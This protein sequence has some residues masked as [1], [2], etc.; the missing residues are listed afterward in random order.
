MRSAFI[1]NERMG[2]FKLGRDH[3]YDPARITRVYDLC[4][5]RGLFNRDGLRVVSPRPLDIK[6]FYEVH[7]PVY[8]ETL[9]TA[10]ESGFEPWMLK[11]GLGTEDCPVFPGLLEFLM[12]CAGAT[13]EAGTWVMDAGYDFAFNPLGGFHHAGRTQAEGFCYVND[14]CL[15]ARRWAD[16]GFRVMIVDVDAHHGNGDQDFFY[17]DPRVFTL[18]FHES[19]KTLYPFGGEVTEIGRGPGLG[20]NVNVPMPAGSDDEIFDF[21]FNEVFPPLIEAFS[22]DVAIGI[23]GVDTF[24]TDPLTNLKMTNN[25]YIRAAKKI[26]RLSPRWIALGAGG[27]NMDNVIRSWTLLW[28][29]ANGLDKGDDAMET[30]GGTFMRDMDLGVS[31]LRDMAARNSGPEKTEIFRQVKEEVVYIKDK[32]FPLVGALA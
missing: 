14:V 19:G 32:V 11:F 1:Y 20:Y 3:P 8:L 22:P 26:Q 25:S 6:D 23:M 29:A 7:E 2:G 9:I 4:R 30:L 31:S 27:Y 24:A 10:D 28:A 13:I 15:I 17:D 16:R 5:R 12:L 18:S 21:A